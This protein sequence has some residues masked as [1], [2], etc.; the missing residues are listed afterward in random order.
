MFAVQNEENLH[1]CLSCNIR[2]YILGVTR[3]SCLSAKYLYFMYCITFIFM[4]ASASYSICLEHLCV[5][6]EK[7][8][9]KEMV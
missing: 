6:V 7:T 3:T 5:F 2:G 8:C 9:C 4:K 1:V